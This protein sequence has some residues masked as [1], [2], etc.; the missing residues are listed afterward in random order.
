MSS[1]SRTIDAVRQYGNLK[2]DA[3]MFLMCGLTYVFLI[4]G[5]IYMLLTQPDGPRFIIFLIF[6]PM[7]AYAQVWSMVK[8][9][10]S[11]QRE[12]EMWAEYHRGRQEY[13]LQVRA[14]LAADPNAMPE[15]LAMQGYDLAERPFYS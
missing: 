14:A 1:L 7:I 12:S 13:L 15:D 6:L 8:N 5:S 3:G 4:A 2:E 9:C 10:L 11:K